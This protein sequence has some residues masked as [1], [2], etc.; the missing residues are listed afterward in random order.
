MHGL[1]VNTFDAHNT[2][3]ESRSPNID[4]IATVLHML[5]N[6]EFNPFY[7]SLRIGKNC[8]VQNSLFY[9]FIP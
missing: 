2:G 8:I 4:S 5:D 3:H 7:I 9:F 6:V 1:V